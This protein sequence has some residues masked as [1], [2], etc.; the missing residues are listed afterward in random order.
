MQA[1]RTLSK[2]EV[3]A[4]LAR[5]GENVRAES[6]GFYDS[7]D[8][9]AEQV[10]GSKNWGRGEVFVH[11][12]ARDRFVIL[13]QVA[14]E[15]CEM[16]ALS[17]SG[18][19]DVL[20]AYRFSQEELVGRLRGLLGSPPE[21]GNAPLSQGG[22]PRQTFHGVQH[23]GT[24]QFLRMSKFDPSSQAPL[25]GPLEE[26]WIA[27]SREQAVAQASFLGD[28]THVAVCYDSSMLDNTFAVDVAYAEGTPME[29]F[30]FRASGTRNGKPVIVGWRHGV[31]AAGEPSKVTLIKEFPDAATRDAVVAVAIGVERA[32]GDGVARLIDEVAD[33]KMGPIED[34]AE[35]FTF[36]FRDEHYKGVQKGRIRDLCL[37]HSTDADRKI[38]VM[39]IV[40]GLA[41][42]T[43]LLE[44]GRRVDQY[45]EAPSP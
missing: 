31:A 41:H 38:A 6:I 11:C 2:E 28:D 29:Q 27:G 4:I 35:T 37:G 43:E 25:Y 23:R 9:L 14:P 44:P 3:Q 16:M 20:T 22:F 8:A 34:G 30:G 26:S 7:A 32:S 33:V 36:R 12:A 18:F 45:D 24:K 17:Q 19:H 1:N 15:S 10:R 13:C 5:Q 42:R 39:A 21:A 40:D